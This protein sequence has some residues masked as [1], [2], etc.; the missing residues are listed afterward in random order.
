MLLALRTVKILSLQLLYCEKEMHQHLLNCFSQ[1][2]LKPFPLIDENQISCSHGAGITVTVIIKIMQF[3]CDFNLYYTNLYCT[4]TTKTGGVFYQPEIF[5]RF[6]Y[7][8]Q[9][10]VLQI[11]HHCL[12]I[13]PMIFFYIT[14]VPIF[15]NSYFWQACWC[16]FSINNLCWQ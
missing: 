11:S 16:F 12:L 9:Q 5:T 1:K 13:R 2:D 7:I 3:I 10:N 15:E 4:N 14:E 8:R 6:S